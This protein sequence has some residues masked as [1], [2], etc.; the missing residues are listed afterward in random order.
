MDCR[1]SAVI[2]CPGNPGI[3]A[4]ARCVP[5]PD[6]SDLTDRA[7]VVALARRHEVDL[8]VVG[9]EAPLVAGV[10]DALRDAGYAVFG[11]SAAAARL[12]GSKAFAKEVM[13]EAEVPTAMAH[14]CTTALQVEEALDAL[15]APHVVKEDGLAA[16][17]G[18]VVT[19]SV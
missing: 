13:A 8:V 6:G 15:G 12:E 16:G 14:V 11:P 4:L 17:K 7:A 18:V 9:P 5:L 1:V 10:A 3:E 19:A 2:A